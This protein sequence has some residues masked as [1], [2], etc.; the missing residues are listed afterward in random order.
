MLITCIILEM[1]KVNEEVICPT[2][3]P[4]T[5]FKLERETD[6]QASQMQKNL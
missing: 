4:A 2:T 1:F 5:N 3:V 6:R